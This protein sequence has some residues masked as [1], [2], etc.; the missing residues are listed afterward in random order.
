MISSRTQ[1]L[2]ILILTAC[3]S[4]PNGIHGTHLW[5]RIK[6][7]VDEYTLLEFNYQLYFLRDANWLV[8]TNKLW[9]VTDYA[10]RNWQE[11]KTA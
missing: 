9:W 1:A 4:K 5:N 8:C 6:K 7:H 10:K 11:A 2:R 3:S